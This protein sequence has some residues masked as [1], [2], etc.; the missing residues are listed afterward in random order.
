VIRTSIA[1]FE[2]A[3]PS[4]ATATKPA[5][6]GV[7]AGPPEAGVAGS[8]GGADPLPPG[9]SAAASGVCTAAPGTCSVAADAAPAG[10]APA[11]S[12]ADGEIDG[13]NRPKRYAPKP[14]AARAARTTTTVMSLFTLHPFAL[15]DPASYLKSISRVRSPSAAIAVPTT[16]RISTVSNSVTQAPCTPMKINVSEIV[17]RTTH[18]AIPHE[19]AA[20]GW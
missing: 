8:V 17:L 19:V 6:A 16:L 1:L 2:T 11:V 18:E 14:A 7:G 12:V 9:V 3:S 5:G 13:P 10:V 4:F 15:P 20:V